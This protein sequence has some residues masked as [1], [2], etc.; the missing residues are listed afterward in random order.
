MKLRD[1][2]LLVAVC[3]FWAT[4]NILSKLAISHWHVPPLFYTACALA[5]SPP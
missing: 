1:F 5:S 2:L 4:N 3:L